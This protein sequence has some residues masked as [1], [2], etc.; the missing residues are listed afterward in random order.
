MKLR[1]IK[2][3][4]KEKFEF[5]SKQPQSGGNADVYFVKNLTNDEDVVLKILRR[6]KK[7]EEKREIKISGIAI[8]REGKVAKITYH[9]KD[10]LRSLLYG[11][12]K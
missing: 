8:V 1:E 7:E 9:D 12:Q 11:E 2:L 6:G 5:S 10:L 3:L 4:F